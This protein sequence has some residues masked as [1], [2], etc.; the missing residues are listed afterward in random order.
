MSSVLALQDT[1]HRKALRAIGSVELIKGFA[2]VLGVCWLLLNVD[3][4]FFS[5]AAMLL[6]AFHVAPGGRL[7]LWMFDMAAK[8]T[9]EKVHSLAMIGAGYA[10]IRFV[11]AYGL[12]R[13]R[14][15]AEWFA[16]FS[17]SVYIPLEIF[18]IL[19]EATVFRGL[20]LLINS[21]ILAYMVYLRYSARQ[22]RA[23]HAARSRQEFEPLRRAG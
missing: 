20:L 13:A 6:S 21:A 8:I 16:I 17:C 14:V 11:E 7:A 12:M 5:T 4:D 1:N 15:W 2:V 3:R 18:E 9:P 22:E 10:A 23:K 19:R